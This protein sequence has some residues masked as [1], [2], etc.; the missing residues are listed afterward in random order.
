[1]DDD[2]F[3]ELLK[4]QPHFVNMFNALITHDS[5]S[6]GTPERIAARTRIVEDRNEARRRR[7]AEDD[8]EKQKL[9]DLIVGEQMRDF[10]N[11]VRIKGSWE[12]AEEYMNV[13][14]R[15]ITSEIGYHVNVWPPRAVSSNLHLHKIEDGV[16][17]DR[18][19]FIRGQIIA[20]L[21]RVP[22]EGEEIDNSILIIAESDSVIDKIWNSREI[23][24]RRMTV[25]RESDM[26]PARMEYMEDQLGSYE[27][28]RTNTTFIIHEKLVSRSTVPF[29]KLVIFHRATETDIFFKAVKELTHSS[30]QERLTSDIHVPFNNLDNQAIVEFAAMLQALRGEEVAS[31]VLD[32]V[33]QHCWMNNPQERALFEEWAQFVK[34]QNTAQEDDLRK[35]IGIHVENWWNS[36]DRVRSV[37][38]MVRLFKEIEEPPANRPWRDYLRADSEEAE[39]V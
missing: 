27:F 30:R 25:I 4:D 12:A 16:H 35:T 38:G 36:I 21:G 17:V 32:F 37:T 13:I 5:D 15:R 31:D 6:E 7:L 34:T 24:Q 10:Q 9:F 28:D 20:F 11:W 1:M 3:R 29:A 2:R 18:I 19:P 23:R 26:V 8:V 33:E 39:A 22:L 14:Y